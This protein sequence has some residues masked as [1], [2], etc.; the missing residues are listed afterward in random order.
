MRDCFFGALQFRENRFSVGFI[1]GDCVDLSVRGK[2]TFWFFYLSAVT[3]PGAPK[4]YPDARELVTEDCIR[5][6]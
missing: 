5:P 4:N 2:S 3:F 1:S 6:Y